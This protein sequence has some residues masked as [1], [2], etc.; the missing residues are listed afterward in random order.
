[1][2]SDIAQ[3]WTT[4]MTVMKTKQSKNSLTMAKTVKTR[5]M[6]KKQNNKGIILLLTAIRK[7]TEISYILAQIDI[8]QKYMK[9]VTRSLLLNKMKKQTWQNK[10]TIVL[11]T[12]KY[13][14]ALGHNFCTGGKGEKEVVAFCISPQKTFTEKPVPQRS[15]ETSQQQNFS[16]TANAM[17]SIHTCN[18]YELQKSARRTLAM[19]QLYRINRLMPTH[20]YCLRGFPIGRYRDNR[21]T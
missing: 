21:Q 17:P 5:K 10:N 7:R 15:G 13:Y 11:K 19:L 14:F 6:P 20:E 9:C 1:M 18:K 16:I 8:M 2:P 3:H 4:C 12:E